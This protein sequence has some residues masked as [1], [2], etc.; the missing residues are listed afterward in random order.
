MSEV[1]TKLCSPDGYFS[2]C[3]MQDDVESWIKSKRFFKTRTK[4]PYRE[5]IEPKIITGFG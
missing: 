3:D 4:Y 1:L 2:E 5:E